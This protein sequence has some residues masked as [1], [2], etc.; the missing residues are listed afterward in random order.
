MLNSMMTTPSHRLWPH[1]STHCFLVL[2]SGSGS[3]TPVNGVR[4]ISHNCKCMFACNS[5]KPAICHERNP[6]PCSSYTDNEPT[7]LHCSYS[8]LIS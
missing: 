8:F 6:P 2:R 3:L 5:A 1:I 4:C 7:L